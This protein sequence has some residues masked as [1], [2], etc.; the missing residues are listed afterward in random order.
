MHTKILQTIDGTWI[1][2][3]KKCSD[4]ILCI[5][6]ICVCVLQIYSN[7]RIYVYI[8]TY[9]QVFLGVYLL[10]G[11]WDVFAPRHGSNN[12]GHCWCQTLE[13]PNTLPETLGP[14]PWAKP[15]RA[16]TPKRIQKCPKSCG[17]PQII[18]FCLGFSMINHLFWGTPTYGNPHIEKIKNTTLLKQ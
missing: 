17:Y 8:H 9:F 6:Y 7:I 1:L 10:F 14:T 16:A 12:V 3:N 2:T 15:Q 13:A 5:C 11:A 4:G 18:H